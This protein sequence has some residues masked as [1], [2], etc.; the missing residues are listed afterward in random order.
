MAAIEYPPPPE[1]ARDF[2]T[3]GVTGTNGKTTTT[4]YVVA[5][6]S[7]LGRPVPN[8]TTLGHALDTEPVDVEVDYDGFLE[9][10]K[11]GHARG[12]RHAVIECTSEALAKGF[13]RAWPCQIAVFTNLS[14]DHLAQHGSPEHYLAS[15]AQLFIQLPPDGVAVLNR[16]DP[17][18]QLLA[19]VVPEH[20]RISWYG[21]EPSEELDFRL[22]RAIPTWRG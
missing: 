22:L 20:A 15:K 9:T 2:V 17:S 7:V 21:V 18:S 4:L 12:G 14:H 19:E 8:V 6:L 1:W 3:V 16:E 11:R 13:M 5:A 10:M